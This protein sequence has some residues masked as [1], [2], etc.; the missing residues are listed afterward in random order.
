MIGVMVPWSAGWEAVYTALSI[1]P[2]GDRAPSRRLRVKQAYET[3]LLP[4]E[5]AVAHALVRSIGSPSFVKC[6]CDLC[7]PANYMKRV[8]PPPPLLSI[9][10]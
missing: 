7:V 2:L 10:D 8:I 5:L 9:S 4:L 6:G 1:D 3:V